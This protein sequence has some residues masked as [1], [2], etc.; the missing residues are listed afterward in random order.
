MSPG[1]ME[2]VSVCHCAVCSSSVGDTLKVPEMPL[3][4][5]PSQKARLFCVSSEKN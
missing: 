5:L 2:V 3:G 1:L 4:S